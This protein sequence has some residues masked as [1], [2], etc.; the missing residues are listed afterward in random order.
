MNEHPESA[1]ADRETDNSLLS[2]ILGGLGHENKTLPSKLLYD[3]TGSELFRRI[4]ELPEYYLTRTERKLLGDCATDIVAAVPAD[5][6]R[7]RALVE[8]G[9]SDESK[10]VSLLDVV[11][12]RF[13]IYLAIDISPSV[14]GP[15]RARM[16][17]SHPRIKV[18]TLLADFMRPFSIR[19]VI[20]HSQAVGFL[21]GS[22]IGQYSPATV[23]QFLENV[24]AA[25]L[26]AGRAG[27][28]IGTDQCRDPQRVLPAYNDSAGISKAFT[29]N[30]LSHVNRLTAGTLDQRNFGHKAIWNPREERVEIYL[31]SRCAQSARIGGQSI[32]F[33][34]GETIR[35]GMSYKYG[36]DRFLSIA[37][38]A[39]W[40]SAGFW[41]DPH[42][43]FAIHLLQADA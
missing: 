6:G 4:T 37:A 42:K 21:P 2:E 23:V 39:G 31:V 1:P 25:F 33:A 10:A 15:I 34:E 20:G 43:V 7:A 12:G 35:T 24:R 26:G 13:A 11:E 9:A 41:Q 5:A 8:F 14:L 38:Q 17:V 19:D 32:S 27:F 40:S 22:T 3:A 36:R 16:Q 29:L 28:V 30:I 18:E